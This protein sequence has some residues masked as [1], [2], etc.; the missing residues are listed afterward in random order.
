[1]RSQT[2]KRTHRAE[3][4]YRSQPHKR[5]HRAEDYID[6]VLR[7]LSAFHGTNINTTISDAIMAYQNWTRQESKADVREGVAE[8]RIKALTAYKRAK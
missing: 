1:M 6:Y 7:R 8:E 5:S 4:Q 2:S 3:P